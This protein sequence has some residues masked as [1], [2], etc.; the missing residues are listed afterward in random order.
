MD[1]VGSK[2]VRIHKLR[3]DWWFTE[4]WHGSFFQKKKMQY[5][6]ELTIVW[7]RQDGFA[8]FTETMQKWVFLKEF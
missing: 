6:V 4:D 7:G 1:K 5:S 2:K 8:T 3:T